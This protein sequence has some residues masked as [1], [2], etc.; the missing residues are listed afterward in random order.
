M[1]SDGVT[2]ARE[3]IK[4][5]T[6]YPIRIERELRKADVGIMSSR[7]D[8]DSKKTLAALYKE[9]RGKVLRVPS[10]Q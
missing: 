7:R 10:S 4:L 8:A 2:S 3:L 1:Q 6:D 5:I 9:L